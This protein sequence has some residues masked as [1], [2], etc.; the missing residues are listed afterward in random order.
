M[1][2]TFRLSLAALQ[3]AGVQDNK[4][5]I[6]SQ[7]DRPDDQMAKWDRRAA[8]LG[9]MLGGRGGARGGGGGGGGTWPA[10]QQTGLWRRRTRVNEAR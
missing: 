10:R 8:S 5:N 2:R 7:H 4:K 3:V 9:L 1:R 6:S